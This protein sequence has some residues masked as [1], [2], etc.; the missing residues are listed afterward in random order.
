MGRRT[1]I[2]LASNLS[3][4]TDIITEVIDLIAKRGSGKTYTATKLAEEM[5]LIGAQV[6]VIDPVGN[7]YGLRLGA[8]GKPAGG[9]DITV[10]G[11]RNGD[12]PLE[13]TAGK[14]IAKTVVETGMS[15]ILDVSM[16]S[17]PKQRRF[18]TDF[19]EALLEFRKKDPSAMHIFW[20]EAYRFMPQKMSKGSKNEML[21]A[22]EELVT[23]GR[24]FGIGGTII[25][26]RS[27][28]ISKT[29]LTQASVLLAM[30]TTGLADRKLIETWVDYHS[31]EMEPMELS[32]LKKGEAYVWWPEEFG[33]KR[34]KVAKK[35]TYDAS[36]T[37]KFGEKS[38]KR[39]LR[40]VD[41]DALQEA[42]KD[43]IEKLQGEDPRLLKRRIAE[44]EKQLAAEKA[45]PPRVETIEVE[46]YDQ[47]L[48]SFFET[49]TQ[50][51]ERLAQDIRK[52]THKKQRKKT[53][54][55]GSSRISMPAT[56][57]KPNKVDRNGTSYSPKALKK[58]VSEKSEDVKITGGALRMLQALAAVYPG[59]L[60]KKQVATAARMK[61]SSGTYGTYW[62]K[63]NT[64][65]FISEE[66]GRWF[67]TEE[68]MDFLGDDVPTQPDSPEEKVA[69]W[70]ER[71]SGKA[72]ELLR[73]LFSNE[74]EKFTKEELGEAVGL[75]H[76]SGTFG[77]YLS[78]LT[79]NNLAVRDGKLYSISPDLLV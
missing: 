61:S 36:S 42:M 71:L 66:K 73:H 7:W 38:R 74:D 37:P 3:F 47:E 50:Q 63:I 68:G 4:G 33:I 39:K 17:K 35:Q 72:R 67:I 30:N 58:A 60:T 51:I 77:T 27:A 48:M 21:E 1:K 75:S 2:H 14:L 9:L 57:L 32:K 59:G 49:T 23:M 54:I 25:C 26:Q 12:I 31:L 24:N 70:C 10:L 8:D 20:E 29:V 55:N 6:V 15:T 45:K 46:L 34:I 11:G 56:V 41:L 64:A 5:L 78:S 76:S 18:I 40:A 79:S 62:S 28:Q 43:T 53:K 44:L 22:T 13:H 65:G 16:L 52:A 69:F 19:S